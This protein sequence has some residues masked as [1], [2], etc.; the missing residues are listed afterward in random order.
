MRTVLVTINIQSELDVVFARQ[1]A[2][3][4]A[5]L[6]QF[7][8]LDQ[9]RISTSVS[10]IARNAFLYAKGGRAQ[11]LFAGSVPERLIIRIS[12]R[13]PGIADLPA[14]LAGHYQSTTGMGLGIAG[15]RK[16]MDTFDAE[17][18]EGT[19]TTVEMSKALPAHVPHA[20]PELVALIGAELAKVLPAGPLEEIRQQNIELLRTLDDLKSRQLQIDQMYRDLSAAH[21]Q[22]V[23]SNSQLETEARALQRTTEAERAARAEAEAAV[24]LREDLLAI[25]SHDLRTPLASIMASAAAIHHSLPKGTVDE[26]LIRKSTNIIARSAQ[27]MNSLVADLLDMARIRTA[28]L[29]I[30]PRPVAVRELIQESHDVLEPLAAQTDVRITSVAANELWVSCD[31][32]RALQIL[33]NLLSNA[34]KFTPGGGVICLEAVDCGTEVLFSV[35][36]TGCGMPPQDLPHVFDRFWQAQHEYGGIGLGLSIVAGL[37]QAHGG[38]VWAESELGVGSKF[39]FTLVRAQAPV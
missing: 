15:S 26:A 21:R 24:A 25:V 3:Q 4:I 27:R 12:D 38:R 10:E 37:V 6:I 2:R 29:R 39:Y 17:S 18:V 22:V 19:G 36:D 33:S 14:V 31:K 7:D 35:S 16:L 11:F 8:T 34:I 28:T 5:A 20:T 32:E 30:E 9:T 23:D 1:R 13:G